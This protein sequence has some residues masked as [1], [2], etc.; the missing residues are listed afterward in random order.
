MTNH[1]ECGTVTPIDETLTIW[2]GR[3]T[4]NLLFI[5]LEVE[6]VHRKEGALGRAAG[7]DGFEAKSHNGSRLGRCRPDSC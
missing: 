1:L 5:D 2:L 6:L 4:R 3:V 7:I